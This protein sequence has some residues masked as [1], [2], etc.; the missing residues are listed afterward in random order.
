M[1]LPSDRPAYC[2]CDG[3][4]EK[5]VLHEKSTNGL[6]KILLRHLKFINFFFLFRLCEYMSI[7]EIFD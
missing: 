3:V 5:C 1:I 2:V 7:H 4:N 6:Y